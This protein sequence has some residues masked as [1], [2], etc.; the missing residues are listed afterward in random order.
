MKESLQTSY[1]LLDI[2]PPVVPADSGLTTLLASI[3]LIILLILIAVLVFRHFTSP[4]SRARRRLRQLQ[5]FVKIKHDSNDN[6][7]IDAV[8]IREAAYQLARL[9]AFGVGINGITS[10]T[11]LPVEL[12]Q[13]QNRWQRFTG[14]LSSA[15]YDRQCSHPSSLDELF[16]D[17]LFWLKN[18][19]S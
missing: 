15:R 13:H 14:T 8:D 4:R 16:N 3:A 17:T 9:L 10:S 6:K 5:N 7:D 2:E 12:K 19:P 11:T 18:W 1:S